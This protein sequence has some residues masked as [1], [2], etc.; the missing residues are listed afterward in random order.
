MLDQFS[1]L[2]SLEYALTGQ[3]EQE[4]MENLEMDVPKMDT[5]AHT[6]YTPSQT[7]TGLQSSNVS[8]TVSPRSDNL[9][10]QM[11]SQQNILVSSCLFSIIST[12]T[13]LLH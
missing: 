1:N 10:K 2:N 6:N 12:Y 13:L 11:P 9:Y 4:L 3:N 5:T 7:E 8:Q